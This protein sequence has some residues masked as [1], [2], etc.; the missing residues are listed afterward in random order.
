MGTF[1]L[2]HTLAGCQEKNL[3]GEA[4][5]KRIGVLEQPRVIHKE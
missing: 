3:V 4:V 2:Y 5:P 1:P